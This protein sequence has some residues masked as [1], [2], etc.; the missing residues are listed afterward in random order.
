MEGRQL[1]VE[2][3]AH[4]APSTDGRD[5]RQGIRIEGMLTDISQRFYPGESQWHLITTNA[6]SYVSHQRMRKL[7]YQLRKGG[8]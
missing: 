4:I 7:S 3:S 6:V 5:G 2:L 1:W 8:E